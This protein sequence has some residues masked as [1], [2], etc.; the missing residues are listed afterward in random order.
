VVYN[1]PVLTKLVYHPGTNIADDDLD[2]A[3]RILWRL[4]NGV[5]TTEEIVVAPILSMPSQWLEPVE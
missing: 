5:P 3:I 1:H 2:I 4:C